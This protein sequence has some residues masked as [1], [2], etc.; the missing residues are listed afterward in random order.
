[1]RRYTLFKNRQRVSMLIGT[2]TSVTIGLGIAAAVTHTRT[3][4]AI[5]ASTDIIASTHPEARQSTAEVKGS[6]ASQPV[7]EVTPNPTP[8][9][10]SPKPTPKPVPA[11]AQ[12]ASPPATPN[13][14]GDTTSPV[15]PP[16]IVSLT[17][18]TLTFDY[19]GVPTIT[20]TLPVTVSV[21]TPV[22][23]TVTKDDGTVLCTQTLTL[24]ANEPKDIAC[25]Y[26]TSEPP[27]SSYATAT[28]GT[29]S[30]KSNTVYVGSLSW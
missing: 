5:Q 13:T 10:V 29:T 26:T 6:S 22:T 4:Q 7:Q 27:L 23:V 3:K 30:A 28:V 12:P 20:F 18:G 15:S 19:T 8:Q 16:P 9:V 21:D 25:G 17:L 24:S 1:M 2:L 14:P 11:A